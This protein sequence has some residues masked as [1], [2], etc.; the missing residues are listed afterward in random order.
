MTAHNECG[1]VQVTCDGG[2][3]TVTGCNHS[4]TLSYTATACGLSSTC[5]RT[6]TWTVATAPVFDNCT[7]STTPLGCNPTSIPTCTTAPAVTAH[8]ECGSV[9]VTCDGGTDTVTGCNH[10]RTLTYTATACG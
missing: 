2:T 10:S 3:D 4:R 7:D 8:N 5:K 9:Q 6:Y 1:S